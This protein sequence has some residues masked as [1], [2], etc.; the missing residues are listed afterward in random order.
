M[1]ESTKQEI[2][3]LLMALAEKREWDHK[4]WKLCHEL[5]QENLT[6]EVLDSFYQEFLTY[7]GLFNIRA[8]DYSGQ[9]R[10]VKV[11]SIPPNPVALDEVRR[12]FTRVAAL[13]KTP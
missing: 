5:I 10:I 2:A 13:L 4:A 1:K 12:E 9:L 6:N 11:L 8:F 7:P 3:D